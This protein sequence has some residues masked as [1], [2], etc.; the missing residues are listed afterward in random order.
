ME[1]TGSR[2]KAARRD[3]LFNAA[4]RWE[5]RAAFRD[6]AK[7]RIARL[8]IGAGDTEAQQQAWSDRERKK[9]E[10]LN[11]AVRR[12]IGPTI[13][14]NP[15]S[16]SQ[17]ASEAAQPVARIVTLPDNVQAA[18]GVAT[19][20]LISG[21]LLLTNYHVF[22]TRS[23][24]HGYGANFNYV[25]AERG[26]DQGI[27][28]ELDPGSFFLADKELDFA[29]IAVKAKGLH[30]EA[31]SELGTIR[32]IEAT[33]KVL[34][35]Q[36]L[37]IVQHPGGGTRQFV[38]TNNRLLDILPAGFLHYETDTEEGSSGSPVSNADWDLVGLHHCGVPLL[39]NGKIITRSGSVWDQNHDD[40]SSIMWVANECVR[41][42]AIVGRLRSMTAASPSEQLI[43]AQLL[44]TT[45]DPLVATQPDRPVPSDTVP[46]SLQGN[47]MPA[48]IFNFTGP[49][50]INVYGGNAAPLPAGAPST[51]HDSSAPLSRPAAGDEKSLVFDP[52]YES[53]KGYDP[54]FLGVKIPP[55]S[56]VP[57]RLAEMYSHD[58]YTEYF[59]AFRNVPRIAD[60]PGSAAVILKYHHYSLAFNKKYKMC[61]WTAS[62]CDYRS[63]ERQDNRVRADLG[64]ENWRYDP[65]VPEELQL[66]NGDVYKPARRI[67][68]G[69]IVRR[70]DNAWG[71]KGLATEY[72][73]SDTYHWTN[74]TPQHEAFN[75]ENPK[76]NNPKNTQIYNGLGVKGI[77]GQF[78]AK[79]ETAL[80][81]GGGQ[82]TIFAGPILDEHFAAVDW[83][84]GNVSIPKTFWKVF[85]IP[86]STAKPTKLQVFGYIFDQAPTVKRFG[87]TYEGVELP[88]FQRQRALLADISK[89]AGVIFP[90]AILRAEQAL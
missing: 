90:D 73:N 58:D 18:Q 28:F 1:S 69:H 41:V 38:F 66:G 49:V 21:N 35:G 25:N 13:D 48:P 10:G 46:I 11:V 20:F 19:G 37:N 8:G 78:E 47:E 7:S 2:I 68:R 53:R 79:L 74:C 9:H 77:W 81:R 14:F 84:N 61:Q 23:E 87:M 52:A 42:S 70:E 82:A 80:T 12:L 39:K 45:S 55:P 5:E 6:D 72:G 76:D 3:M 83:G 27:F 17:R 33:G 63:V 26:V 62:N 4:Q 56:V 32:L 24:V 60:A 43:L 22:S 88:Q 64:G 59:E 31:L 36:P 51:Q 16:P 86:A 67:D 40:D 29:I 65:R 34:K 54:M 71:P 44:A 85:I 30:G 57:S 75:Q 15:F 50:T 89:R